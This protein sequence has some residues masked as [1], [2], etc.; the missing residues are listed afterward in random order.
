M[1]ALIKISKEY[2][3]QKVP[4]S[5]IENLR[6]L[7]SRELVKKLG[8]SFYKLPLII[9]KVTEEMKFKVQEL[10]LFPGI[11]KVLRNLREHPIQLGILT[12][13]TVENVHSF[14]KKYDLNFFDFIHTSK[15]LFGKGRLLKKILMNVF[16]KSEK[17]DLF[18]VGDETRDVEA[19]RKAG[20]Q[21]ISVSWGFNTIETL[22]KSKPDYLFCTP[23]ELWSFFQSRITLS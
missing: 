19:A 21:A 11:E 7:D 8:I 2:G 10:S 14:L 4:D 1:L 5:E 9:Q 12:S 15:T 20:F 16:S 6:K 13:N 3:I 18:Y 22:Q 23:E 17:K